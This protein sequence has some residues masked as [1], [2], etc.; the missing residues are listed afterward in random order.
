MTKTA[1]VA[2][3]GRENGREKE[4][5]SFF[6][7]ENW[8]QDTIILVM[9]IS[10]LVW[11]SQ[12]SRNEICTARWR[13][14]KAYLLHNIIALQAPCCILI[15]FF[16]ENSLSNYNIQGRKAMYYKKSETFIAIPQFRTSIVKGNILLKIVFN[17]TLN[18][19]NLTLNLFNLTL[20]LFNLTLNL[21]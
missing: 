11:T 18:L 21:Q 10:F 16:C 1:T 19:F 2:E 7:R 14:D 20:N 9:N 12:R 4:K 8:R 6:P 13:Y 3:R 5:K 15:L 17:L